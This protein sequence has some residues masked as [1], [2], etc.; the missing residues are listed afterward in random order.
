MLFDSQWP[1]DAIAAPVWVTN[2]QEDE[3]PVFVDDRSWSPTDIRSDQS[4]ETP[5]RCDFAESP[6]RRGWIVLLASVVGKLRSRVHQRREIR[7]VS[8][9]WAMVDD[10]TLKDIGISR[11]EL[12]Y[13]ADVRHWADCVISRTP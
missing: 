11:L 13:A 8:A 6:H 5:D 1:G 9:A 7:R 12:E 4:R 10:R 3:T 2:D